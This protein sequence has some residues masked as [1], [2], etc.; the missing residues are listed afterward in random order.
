ME[1]KNLDE[2]GLISDRVHENVLFPGSV[3]MY[4]FLVCCIYQRFCD[5]SAC[6]ALS[7]SHHLQLCRRKIIMD[8]FHVICHMYAPEYESA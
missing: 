8:M 4:Y 1:T 6:S 7:M 3:R 5:S 2:S